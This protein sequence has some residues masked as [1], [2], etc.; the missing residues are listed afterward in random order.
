MIGEGA[1]ATTVFFISVSSKKS[2]SGIKPYVMPES[3]IVLYVIMRK[4]SGLIK[5]H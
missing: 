1:T 3:E 4:S 2:F 5:S